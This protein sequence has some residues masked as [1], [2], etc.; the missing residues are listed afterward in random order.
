MSSEP[1]T[2]SPAEVDAVIEAKQLGK[3]YHIYDRPQDRLKQMLWRGRRRFYREFWALRDVSFTVRRGETV[4]VIGRN[5]S[6][7]STLLKLLCG[8]LAPTTGALAVRGRVAALLELG[9]GFNPEFTGRENVYL[10]AAILGLDDAEIE[11]YLP[12]ILEFADIGDFVD[13]P[14]KTYSSGMAVRLAFAVA[15]HVRADILVI[16]EALSVGDVFFVQKCMRFLRQFQEEGTLFFVSHDTGA[17]INLCDR[18]LWLEHGQ[19]HEAGPA[20]E[21]CEHYLAILRE[22][23]D[24]AGAMKRSK[25]QPTAARTNSRRTAAVDQRLAFLNQTRYRNDLELFTF[26]RE[27][28][29][30]GAGAIRIVDAMFEDERGNPLQWIVGGERVTLVAHA[31]VLE[32]VLNPIIGFFIKDRLGQNLFGDNTYLTY[33]ANPRLA[34]VGQSLTARFTFRMPVLPVGDYSV[35]IAAASGTQQDHVT[36]CWCN[37]VLAFKSHASSTHQGLIGI[38]MLDIELSIGVDAA[39]EPVPESA[40]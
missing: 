26:R 18:V 5:G 6:G 11:R 23:P 30:Y 31:W 34:T 7:K 14:V 1:A 20:K 21:I 38:P 25:D 19:L 4:G 32:D 37:D 35:D 10:N 17:V 16:D 39:R 13:Q 2:L 8:T 36:H 22:P 28:A 29:G 24:A 15:A 3:C 27:V 9:T 40:S 33:T 12:E